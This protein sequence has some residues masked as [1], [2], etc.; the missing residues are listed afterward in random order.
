[1]KNN[2]TKYKKY[3]QTFLYVTAVGF[4]VFLLFFVVTFS[5]IGFE[6]KDLC[7]EAKSEYQG[8]CVIALTQVLKNENKSFRQRNDAI[9]ALGQ[10]GDKRALATLKSL[11]TGNIPNRE[12]LGKMISQYELKKAIKLVEGGLNVGA[13]IWR[14]NLNEK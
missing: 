7:R 11:Y 14:G 3:I 9:W 1:M 6:V 2:Q 5:W 4:S 8:D 13:F 10:L 12:P